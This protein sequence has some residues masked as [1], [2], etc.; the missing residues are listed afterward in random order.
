MGGGR[1]VGLSIS[2]KLNVRW[3]VCV[4]TCVTFACAL[5]ERER[6]REAVYAKLGERTWCVRV[7]ASVSR[8]KKRNILSSRQ[9]PSLSPCL[10]EKLWPKLICFIHY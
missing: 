10:I 3:L 7:F 5:L 6:E 9:H 8:E 1:A 2:L 4:R